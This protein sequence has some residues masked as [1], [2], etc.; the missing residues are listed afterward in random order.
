MKNTGLEE[1][2]IYG[3]MKHLIVREKQYFS[4]KELTL[5]PGSRVTIRDRAAYGLMVI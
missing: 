2:H 3:Y 4:A 5:Y 1:M